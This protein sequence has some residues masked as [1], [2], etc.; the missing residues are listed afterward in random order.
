MR[1]QSFA[2]GPFSTNVY[3]LGCE[4]TKEAAIVDPSFESLS[5]IVS[6]LEAES[7]V[8]KKILITHSH[9]DHNADAAA[10]KKFFQ[11]PIFIHPLDQNN[12]SN[13]GSDGLPLLFSIEGVEPS[14]FLE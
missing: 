10:V 13:P 3:L 12:L 6:L 2:A 11:I 9:L 5:T 1:I 8:P 7:L 4:K 14:G